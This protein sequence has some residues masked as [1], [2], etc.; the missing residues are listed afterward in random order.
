[1]SPEIKNAPIGRLFILVIL[2]FGSIG[3]VATDLYLPSLPSIVT[4]FSTTKAYVQLTLSFY[5][6]FFGVSQFFYGPL[7]EK[8]GRKKVVLYGL[9]LTI[10]GSIVCIFSPNIGVLIVG[11]SIEGLGVGAGATMMRVILRD[12]YI[13]DELAK[14]GSYIAT[15]TGVFMA[16]APIIGGYIQDFFGWRFNFVFI[17]LYT[18]MGILIVSK[19]LPETIKELNPHAIKAKNMLNKYFL[20]IK[21]PIFMGY[22]GCGCLTFS[23][24]AAYLAI[25]PFLFQNVIGITPVQYGWLALFIATGLA[26]G[27]LV[28]SLVIRYFGRHK[29]LKFGTLL[30]I[31]AGIAM[32][33][34]GIFRFLNIWSVMIPMLTYMFAAGFVFTNAFAGAFHFF[35]KMA[36]F[37]GA[38][39]G[40][41]Q[42]LGG[43]VVTII[44]AASHA[45]NQIP[46]AITL[47]CIG[48]F[49]Y[50]LQK[51]GHQF[52]LKKD[53]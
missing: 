30:Q 3:F 29:L 34:L 48:I 51:L 15:G 19:F 49:S 47:L 1:M 37:A 41:L 10:V 14:K 44:M 6:L 22:A 45:R 4:G 53:V 35:S 42:I 11:R 52:T 27:G 31:L 38:I 18:L 20:L 26:S 7:S 23:G 43:T 5:L 8:V 17:V 21:S 12:L 50:F 24:L 40:G 46:L 32:L 9:S 13:G 39:Y 16:G 2:M 36:G 33:V 25:S 28:N